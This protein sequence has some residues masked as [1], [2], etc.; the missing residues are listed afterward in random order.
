[1]HGTFQACLIATPPEYI[2]VRGNVCTSRFGG[3]REIAVV[4][5][6]VVAAAAAAG[7]RSAANVVVEAGWSIR[8]WVWL[9]PYP[10]WKL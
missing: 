6:V 3:H 1:M 4:V 5:V 2:G 7:A 10:L 8:G 9:R